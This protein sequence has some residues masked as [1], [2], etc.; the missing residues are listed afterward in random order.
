MLASLLTQYTIV[1]IQGALSNLWD[2]STKFPDIDNIGYHSFQRKILILSFIFLT[3][4]DIE[5]NEK[6]SQL[7]NIL[8]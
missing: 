8:S 2:N 4:L 6:K 5:R 1:K 7:R 3:R